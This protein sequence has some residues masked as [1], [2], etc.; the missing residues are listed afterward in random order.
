MNKN[1]TGLALVES[2]LIILIL[3][4]VGF[5]G[6]YIWNNQHDKSPDNKAATIS[7]SNN[8]SPS[9]ADQ[10]H[11]TISEWDVRLPYDGNLH[12][13]YKM[14]TVN[15]TEQANITSAELLQAGGNDCAAGG[16]SIARYTGDQTWILPD[17]SSDGTV[18]E[19]VAKGDIVYYGKINNYYFV[20]TSGQAACADPAAID[21]LQTDTLATVKQAITKL[22]SE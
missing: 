21:Q 7:D 4:V 9:N 5:G 14:E 1:Q 19:A 12:L 8:S 22:T 18:S 17:G 10:R 20:H 15:G 2:L 6:Y 3:A 16:G 13:Q 11:L